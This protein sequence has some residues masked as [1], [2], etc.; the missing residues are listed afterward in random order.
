MITVGFTVVGTW[1]KQ[2]WEGLIKERD[3]YQHAG[4]Q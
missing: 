2:S 3:W 1:T 4:A